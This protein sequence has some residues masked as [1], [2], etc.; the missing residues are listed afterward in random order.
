MPNAKALPVGGI[1]Q[2]AAVCAFNDMV[3]DHAFA[4]MG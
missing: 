3:G 1:Q 2:R 4:A